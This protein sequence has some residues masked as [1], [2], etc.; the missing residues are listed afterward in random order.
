LGELVLEIWN[1]NGWFWSD[2]GLVR[3]KRKRERK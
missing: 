3:Q 1:V 2:L